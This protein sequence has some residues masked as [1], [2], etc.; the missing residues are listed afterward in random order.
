[1]SFYPCSGTWPC[2]AAPGLSASEFYKRFGPYAEIASNQLGWPVSLILA[3]WAF[4]SGWNTY[5]SCPESTSGCNYSAANSAPCIGPSEDC[6]ICGP[7]GAAS[8]CGFCGAV[9]YGYIEWAQDNTVHDPGGDTTTTYANYVAQAYSLGAY[10][11]P[12]T[13]GYGCL[14]GDGMVSTD[15][16]QA[17]AM[18]LGASGW[19]QGE[20]CACTIAPGYGDACCTTASVYAGQQLYETATASFPDYNY[21][22]TTTTWPDEC[23]SE[24]SGGTTPPSGTSISGSDVYFYAATAM[25]FN[26]AVAVASAL[27]VSGANVTGNYNQ[28]YTWAESLDNLLIAVGA[29]AS[30]EM[31]YNPCAWNDKTAGYTPFNLVG[32]GPESTNNE[33][34]VDQ[35]PPNDY[36]AYNTPWFVNAGGDGE[37]WETFVL[38][39]LLGYYAINGAWPDFYDDTVA[40]A[41]ATPTNYC[42]SGSSTPVSCTDNGATN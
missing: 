39:Y 40:I 35:L 11:M 4:E 9:Y 34:P 14:P 16:L 19:A 7:S 31:Y 13:N 18:A 23:G 37:T 24:S 15:A 20:Y 2:T 21:V 8:Y 36:N 27:G 29:F 26:I 28:A 41:A 6:D 33:T 25:D 30:D 5:D 22:S 12:S 32:P 38:A 42:P 17:A 1:M 3:Q 10:T